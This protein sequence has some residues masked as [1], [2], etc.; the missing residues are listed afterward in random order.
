MAIRKQLQRY[1][2]FGAIIV[3]VLVI[4]VA[5]AMF[6]SAY[7]ERRTSEMATDNFYGL[8]QKQADMFKL[9]FE[10]DSNTLRVAASMMTLSD[11]LDDFAEHN[12][13]FLYLEDT[14]DY[15]AVA[16]LEGNAYGTDGNISDIGEREYYQQAVA[17]ETVISDLIVSG[18]D[19]EYSVT[20]ATPIIDNEGEIVGVM[21]GL[22]SSKS[23]GELFGE[24]IVEGLEFS[25]IVDK[26]GD[27]IINGLESVSEFVVSKNIYDLIVS[28]AQ[29]YQPI[30]GIVDAVSNGESGYTSHVF[31]EEPFYIAYTPLGIRDWSMISILPYNQVTAVTQDIISVTSFVSLVGLLLLL[32]LT[33]I[34]YLN[35]RKN[36]EAVSEVAYVS[37]LTKVATGQKFRIDAPGFMKR[38]PGQ[39]MMIIKFDIENFKLI[40][41]SLGM[42]YGDMVLIK[43]AEAMLEDEPHRLGAHLHDDEFIMLLAECDPDYGD[44]A[45][46]KYVARFM[47]LLGSDFNYKIRVVAGYYKYNLSEKIP[48]SDA[49]ERANIAH[50]R[51]K[52]THSLMSEYSEELVAEAVKRKNIENRMEA[53]ILNKEFTMVLQPEL[54]LEKGKM[55]AAEAL[56]RWQSEDGPMRPDEFVP[57]FEQNGFIVKLDLY[58]FEEACSYLNGWMAS[59]RTP[60]TVSVNF[61]RLHLLTENFVDE[62]N[63][64]SAKYNVPSQYLGIEITET[65]MLNNEEVFLAVMKNLQSN[66]YKVLMDDFGSGFSSLG[67]LKNVSIDVLKLDRSFLMGSKD[68]DRS[69]AVVR[70]VI[71]LSNDLGISTIAEGVET[72]EDAI[73]LKEMGCD[74]IQGYYYGKPMSQ[75]ALK[76]FFDSEE[77]TMLL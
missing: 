14:F 2:T 11:S 51:A 39:R 60:I 13:E 65:N 47:E 24:N 30:D 7:I 4:M 62:L 67:L 74:I 69:I 1:L 64:I 26:E 38:H 22:N 53:A 76:S 34:I 66:G 46:H 19:G 29:S 44:N 49:I 48:V 15:I 71:L 55:I 57:V 52:G 27:V 18:F 43:M 42:Q 77:S 70:S 45:Y 58:M 31:D 37:E 17:G 41:E 40:N 61:S 32:I 68:R 54:S 72:L 9:K 50:R 25:A 20:V 36:L 75:E 73:I 3:F 35:N 33:L 6:S 12:Q 5:M 8:M 56:V 59:G 21:V 28:E 10:S 63:R 23:L 16:D